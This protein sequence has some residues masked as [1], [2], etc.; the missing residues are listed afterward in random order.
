MASGEAVRLEAY[1]ARCVNALADQCEIPIPGAKHGLV[2][3]YRAFAT[4]ACPPEHKEAHDWQK[5]VDSLV[6]CVN[7]NIKKYVNGYRVC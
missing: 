7:S 1:P 4:V 5:R 6:H 2:R 3:K